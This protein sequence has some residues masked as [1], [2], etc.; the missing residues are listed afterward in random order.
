MMEACSWLKIDLMTFAAEPVRKLNFKIVGY[1]DE[2]FVEPSDV[3][4]NVPPDREVAAHKAID[5]LGL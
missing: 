3:Q 5:P 4:S 1:A 2:V